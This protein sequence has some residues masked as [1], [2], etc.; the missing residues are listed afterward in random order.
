MPNGNI[1]VIWSEYISQVQATDYPKYVICLDGQT[2]EELWPRVHF[3]EPFKKIPETLRIAPNGDIIGVG[4]A[5]FVTLYSA[6]SPVG[7]SAFRHKV[8][9]CGSTSITISPAKVRYMPT[10][11]PY[12]MWLFYLMVV[13]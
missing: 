5:T 6:I 9:Y 2:G 4:T 8:N 3:Y 11:I 7:Y 12:P 10:N 1:A 13:L